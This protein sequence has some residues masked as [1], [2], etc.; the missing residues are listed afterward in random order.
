[1]SEDAML[2]EEIKNEIGKLGLS[3]RLLLIEDVWDEIAK[4]NT[5]IPL[6]Q[7]QKKELDT[8]LAAYQ[9]RENQTKAW[10]EVHNEL[11]GKYK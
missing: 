10:H 8:R 6:P 2:T 5:S 9:S 4:S 7:W 1:V 11:R 3:D